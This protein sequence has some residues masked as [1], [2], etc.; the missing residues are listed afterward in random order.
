MGSGERPVNRP[1]ALGTFRL[2]T[3][4][5]HQ[6]FLTG[7]G[8]APGLGVAPWTLEGSPTSFSLDAS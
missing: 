5:I 2:L 4:S 1:E 3:A 6:G 8:L 7:A